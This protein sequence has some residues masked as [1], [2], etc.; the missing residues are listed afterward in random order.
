M[1]FLFTYATPIVPVLHSDAYEASTS[2]SFYGLVLPPIK[3]PVSTKQ[4]HSSLIPTTAYISHL[5]TPVG[6]G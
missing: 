6:L 3:T 1:H 2:G 4:T 5:H